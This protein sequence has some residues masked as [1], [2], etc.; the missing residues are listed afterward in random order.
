[1]QMKYS[2]KIFVILFLVQVL[3]QTSTTFAQGSDTTYL[4]S[5]GDHI[6]TSITG[7]DDPFINTKFSL[8][9]GT[10]GFVETEI[11]ITIEGSDKT[12][13]F[14]PDIF[15][16]QGGV[17]FQY[18]VRP[19]AALRIKAS[20]LAS[21]GNNAISLASQGIDAATNFGIGWL[22]KIV[23]DD[24]LLL[25]TA[26]DLNSSTLTF[27]DL[28]FRLDSTASSDTL[29]NRQLINNFQSLTSNIEFRFAFRIS[30][31]FGVITKV[32]AGLGEVYAEKSESKFKW[33][34]GLLLSIDLRNWFDIPFGVAIG[35]TAVSNEW[36]FKEAAPPIYTVNLN[37]AF[38]NRNDF[39][40]GFENY[41]QPIS[42]ERFDKTLKFLYT[43]IYMSYYF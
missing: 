12:I 1:M 13:N 29:V 30:R 2:N 5:L 3:L 43:K 26:I 22:L 9:F 17:E 35:A 33:N 32:S 7:V 16:A 20:G 41:F 19:W 21:L 4:P 28:G 15:Y 37:I 34:S 23:E 14:K 8:F 36:R 10:A 40:V 39:T 18:A 38:I 27:V 31:V 25:S 6:F 11:P 24:N 42:A